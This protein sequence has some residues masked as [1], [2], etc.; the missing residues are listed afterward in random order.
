MFDVMPHAFCGIFNSLAL[1]TKKIS[2]LG[3]N[4]ALFR[5]WACVSFYFWVLQFSKNKCSFDMVLVFVI[6]NSCRIK[7]DIGES[8]LD[9]ALHSIFL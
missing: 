2:F 5:K 6:N 8:C 9:S 3:S 7:S 1:F 4:C